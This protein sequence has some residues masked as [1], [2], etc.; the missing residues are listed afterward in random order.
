MLDK[1]ELGKIAKVL[2][3]FAFKSKEYVDDGIRVIRITNV[4]KGFI[5]DDN[6]RFIDIQ[7][8]DEFAN[9]LL[10]EGDI[11][12]S[13]TGN[14]GRVGVIE[15]SMLPAALNQRVGALKLK[16]ENVSPKYLFHVLNSDSFEKDAI[17]N[18][19]GVA[20][21]NLSSKWVEKYQIPVPPLAEQKRIA[22]ILDAAEVL[23]AK[24]R[25]S[26][27]QLDILLQSIFL[28]MFGDTHT[29]PMAWEA[30]ELSDVV[31][32]G[33]IV[34]YGIV[35]AGDEFP[36]GVPYIRTGDLIDGEIKLDGLRHTDPGIAAK[37]ERSRVCAGE[38]VMS[39]RATVGTTAL[40][41]PELDGANLTQGT[42]RISPGKETEPLFLLHFVRSQGTQTWLQRQI[43]G[44]TFREITLRRLREMPIHIPPMTL[45]SRFA[46]IVK[47]V[48]QQKVMQRA[49]LNELDT[50]FASLQ[51][52]AF[53]GEL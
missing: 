31:K 13:L 2:N 36:D 12:I 20:Q 25:E 44:A 45:Q 51:S 24:R 48:E 19:K 16:S 11:L 46:A 7:R 18:S 49:H 3:G 41:P 8:R 43:K 35:Q 23:R 9:F 14:V 22:R 40:V 27:A 47:S 53:R 26:L 6:P 5:Q 4:Q 21:L 52:Q 39:I 10:D 32:A 1:V 50:L 33:T 37:F 34:T 29:N 30:R 15:T 42:A 38:I 17:K 28:D